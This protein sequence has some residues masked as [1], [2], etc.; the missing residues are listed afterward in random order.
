MVSSK[1]AHNKLNPKLPPHCKQ[2]PPPGDT[3]PAAH[4]AELTGTWSP[5]IIGG[6]EPPSWMLTPMKILIPNRAFNWDQPTNAQRCA[7][8]LYWLP[9]PGTFHLDAITQ[10]P[11]EPIH[12]F[13]ATASSPV[14][15]PLFRDLHFAFTYSH[16]GD[17]ADIMVSW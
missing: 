6:S 12:R 14:P 5:Y 4:I 1:F 11:N 3:Q 17:V 10:P 13:W 15:E 2:C 9:S 8:T 7:I 16:L